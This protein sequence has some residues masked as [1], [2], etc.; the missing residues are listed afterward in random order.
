MKLALCH[1]IKEDKNR[2]S[3][4]N[5]I[6]LS[7]VLFLPFIIYF[8]QQNTRSDDYY[9]LFFMFL[10]GLTDFLDGRVARYL[11]QKSDLGRIL[12]PVIDKISIGIVMLVLAAHKNLPLWYALIVVGRDVTL[13]FASLFV[14]SKIR[15]V[16]ESDMLGKY[17]ATCLALVIITFTI[18][19]PLAKWILLGISLLLIPATLIS[20]YKTQ[21][22]AI[23]KLKTTEQ[24]KK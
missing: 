3:V 13:L 21:Q 22:K 20:Y 2:F 15:L 6:T 4:A 8:L 7:R 12:D 18:D 17:T 5:F 19:V 23:K 14:I 24:T 16:V 10:A 11:N 9:A 1:I